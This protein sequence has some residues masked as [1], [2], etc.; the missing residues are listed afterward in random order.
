MTTFNPT[1]TQHVTLFNVRVTADNKSIIELEWELPSWYNSAKY[2][3][4]K[5]T[6][7]LADNGYRLIEVIDFKQFH[8]VYTM[9]V[10]EFLASAKA[11]Y[12]AR[13]K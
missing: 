11:T 9:S 13:N 6:N 12:V 10:E 4:T 7:S 8:K 2:M 3:D 5:L 1:Y